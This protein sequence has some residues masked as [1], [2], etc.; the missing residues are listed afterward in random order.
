MLPLT[1]AHVSE[2]E[3]ADAPIERSWIVEGDPAARSATLARSTDGL[4]WT[5]L[6]DCTAGV[7]DWR[8]SFDET[9]HIVDGAATVVDADGLEWQLAPGDVVTF[10]KG[11]TA[12][13]HV[14]AYVRKV[15]FCR[16]D[17]PRW[18]AVYARGRRTVGRRARAAVD[19]MRMGALLVAPVF[20]LS[21]ELVGVA[22]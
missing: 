11:T 22:A 14:P 3:M 2:A 10:R 12:R 13:W 18:L 15:A 8:Y 1:C 7:F 16:C 5:A 17:V 21:L 19:R 9:V 20:S 4:T 6:W